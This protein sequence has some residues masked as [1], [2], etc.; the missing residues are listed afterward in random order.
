MMRRRL[1]DGLK[2]RARALF[3][4][5]YIIDVGNLPTRL[6]DTSAS[7]SRTQAMVPWLILLASLPLSATAGPSKSLGVS[8]DLIPKYTPSKSG[9]WKCLDGSKE[10]S[11]D[12]VNDD[13]CDCPDGSDEPGGMLKLS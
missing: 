4:V 10:I 2:R 11:W 1:V 5:P 8:P 9:T 3:G 7:L 13:F 12:S 6:K